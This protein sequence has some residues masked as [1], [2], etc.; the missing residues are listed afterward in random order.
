MI[1]A[2]GPIALSE[3]LLWFVVLSLTV[4]FVYNGLHCETPGEAARRGLR[5][6]ATFL[7]GTLALAFV[8]HLLSNVL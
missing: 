1:A 5:R 2:V 4:F 7:G 8:F 6:W 3:H